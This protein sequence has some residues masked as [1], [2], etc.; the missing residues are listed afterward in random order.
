MSYR[1]VG[2]DCIITTVRQPSDS[3]P[4]GC[5]TFVGRVS[6]VYLE[7]SSPVGRVSVVYFEFWSYNLLVKLKW[8][9]WISVGRSDGC[10]TAVGRLSVGCRSGVGRESDTTVRQCRTAVGRFF[11]KSTDIFLSVRPPYVRMYVRVCVT[12]FY[13]LYNGVKLLVYANFG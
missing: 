13:V 6:V 7:H 11:G 2:S 9:P 8:K 12:V 4:T 10:R 3:R 1:S 5:H